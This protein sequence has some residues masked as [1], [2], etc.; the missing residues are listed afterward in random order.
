MTDDPPPTTDHR[1]NP[2]CWCAWVTPA[3]ARGD[4]ETVKARLAEVPVAFREVVASHAR[5]VWRVAGR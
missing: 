4:A 5:T 1:D 2:G 3:A